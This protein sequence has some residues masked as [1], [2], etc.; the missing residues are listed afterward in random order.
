[1]FG[2]TLV[3]SRDALW[4]TATD[5]FSVDLKTL[6]SEADVPDATDTGLFIRSGLRAARGAQ[7]VQR[8][9]I[10]TDVAKVLDCSAEE[11]GF[12]FMDPVMA[13]NDSDPV[14][15][16]DFRASIRAAQI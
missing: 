2:E 1:M 14:A 5:S 9:S 15:M 3:K 8:R 4:E 13:A 12:L 16:P 6:L 10:L 11:L 7:T